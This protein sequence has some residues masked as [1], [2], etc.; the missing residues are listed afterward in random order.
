MLSILSL[1][2]ISG[3]AS[4]LSALDMESVPRELRCPLSGKIL[5]DAASTPC[6]NKVVSDA[7]LRERLF[8]SAQFQCPMCGQTGVSPDDVSCEVVIQPLLHAMLL[9]M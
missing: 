4:S 8:K 5:R 1:Y 3:A 9:I 7:T 2:F 6:C